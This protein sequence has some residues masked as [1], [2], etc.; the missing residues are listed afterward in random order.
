MASLKDSLV[1][2]V[3][4]VAIVC[5]KITVT[6]AEDEIAPSPAIETGTGCAAF[7]SVAGVGSCVLFYVIHV[8]MH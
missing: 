4:L 1:V 8:L 3:V 7:A 5:S 2:A 6:A